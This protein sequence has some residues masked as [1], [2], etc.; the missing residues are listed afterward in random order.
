MLRKGRVSPF[1]RDR[2]APPLPKQ[3]TLGNVWG[4]FW[5]SQLERMLLVSA[6]Q[7]PGML[8]KSYNSQDSPSSQRVIQA[9]TPTALRF[10]SPQTREAEMAGA[11][12]RGRWIILKGNGSL[13]KIMKD[14]GSLSTF[15]RGR[16]SRREGITAPARMKRWECEG[17]R[18]PQLNGQ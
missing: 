11:Y 8:L 4:H 9:Q 2:F 13:S 5:L 1:L 7:R 18:G 10:R 16:P 3:G 15:R 6:G 14:N 12:W 17:G